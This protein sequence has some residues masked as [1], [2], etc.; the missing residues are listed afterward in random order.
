MPEAM[1]AD[2]NRESTFSI[3][4]QLGKINIEVEAVEVLSTQAP[5]H[6]LVIA[7][8]RWSKKSR[9][10]PCP[11]PTSE[12]RAGNKD[13]IAAKASSRSAWWR[14]Y[15]G[16]YRGFQVPSVS[17][18]QKR[19]NITPVGVWRSRATR[20]NFLNQRRKLC[21]FAPLCAVVCNSSR[22]FIYQRAALLKQLCPTARHRGL[23]TGRPVVLSDPGSVDRIHVALG[24]TDPGPER[25]DGGTAASILR[26]GGSEEN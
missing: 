15:P 6:R 17:F 12:M 9:P 8:C 13:G 2:L 14:K 11:G 1:R 21:C 18:P 4:E 5:A 22:T 23:E 16:G 26:F 10:L 7:L 19:Y 20:R 24:I 25:C 3:P